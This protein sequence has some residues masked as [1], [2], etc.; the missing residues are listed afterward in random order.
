VRR[1]R[2]RRVIE[3]ELNGAR[4]VLKGASARLPDR[5]HFLRRRRDALRAEFNLRRPC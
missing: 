2:T 3:I 5:H 4:L 1:D